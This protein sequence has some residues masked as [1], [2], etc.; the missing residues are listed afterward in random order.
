VF[1]WNI[2]IYI[3][4][5][6]YLLLSL[7]LQQR[8]CEKVI[9]TFSQFSTTRML[10]SI[11]IDT[12]R[13]VNCWLK[14]RGQWNDQ[15]TNCPNTNRPINHPTWNTPRST[16]MWS[17]A[18]NSVSFSWSSNSRYSVKTHG[19]QRGTYVASELSTKCYKLLHIIK[20]MLFIVM[21]NSV[22]L[23]W[24][25]GKITKPLCLWESEQDEG[26]CNIRNLKRKFLVSDICLFN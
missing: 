9:Y 17:R 21:T 23:S 24:I 5:F 22:Q 10:S 16:Q 13:R 12:H 11:S 8:C 6:I 19:R 20:H 4:I 2:Y 14:C 7:N 1:D 15:L 25:F 3:Y 18:N 26:N